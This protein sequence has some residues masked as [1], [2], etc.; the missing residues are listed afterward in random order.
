ME[1][2]PFKNHFVVLS[3]QKDYVIAYVG[4]Y[5]EIPMI[6]KLGKNNGDKQ[7]NKAIVCDLENG[8]EKILNI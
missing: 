7:L 5:S 1:N 3:L 6:F 2:L 4:F 8:K